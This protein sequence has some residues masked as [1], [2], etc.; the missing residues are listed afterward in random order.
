MMPA[1]PHP[2]LFVI[3]TTLYGIGGGITM[4]SLITLLSG[5]APMEQRGV[6]MSVNGTVFRLGQTLGPVVMGVLY[7]VAGMGGVFYGGVV[8][9]LVMLAV[10]V[11][12]MR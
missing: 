7:G 8:C 12:F 5:L 6:L 10:V 4:P 1:I 3:P 11:L 9:A 2:W